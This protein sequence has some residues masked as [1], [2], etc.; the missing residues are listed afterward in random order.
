MKKLQPPALP[1]ATEAEIQTAGGASRYVVTLVRAL[2]AALEGGGD[3]EPLIRR[4]PVR[5]G[6][7]YY[8]PSGMVHAIGGG[9]LL[10]EIQQSSDVT[11]RL[12]DYNRVNAAGEKRPLHIRQSLDVI[13]P[14]LKGEIARMPAAA[15][16]GV[17][18]LLDVPAFRLDCACVNG[19][20]ELEP[21]PHAFRMVTALAGLLLSWQGDA[22]ELKAGDSVLLPASCPP[23]TLMGGGQARISTPPAIG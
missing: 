20:C 17:F 19:E 21:A 7:V 12:W 23:V 16:G 10:Y 22:M 8:M 13:V 9:I 4:V 11:Y 2:R 5:A 15:D 3:V 6:D 1:A 14:G 18:N